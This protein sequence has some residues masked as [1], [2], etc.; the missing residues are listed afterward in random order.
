[1]SWNEGMFLLFLSNV[2]II[3]VIGYSF[4]YVDN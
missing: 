1:M 3:V 4:E 2:T